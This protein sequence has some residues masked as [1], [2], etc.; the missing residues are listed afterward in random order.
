MS[1]KWSTRLLAACTP[2]LFCSC[3]LLPQHSDNPP[4]PA[5]ANMAYT[6]EHH[7]SALAHYAETL[8]Q[9][10]PESQ[11]QEI[12]QAEREYA[13][14]R[15]AIIRLRLAL[16]LALADDEFRDLDRASA[17]LADTA[18]DADYPVH[19][20]LGRLLSSLVGSLKIE[21]EKGDHCTLADHAAP[22]HSGLPDSAQHDEVSRLA[23]ELEMER[24]HCRELQMKL[25]EL[26][27]IERQF[28]EREQPGTPPLER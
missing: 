18:A 22:V 5:V 13:G 26:K 24:E 4:R 2:V 27:A 14:D 16:A 11:R 23:A 21:D 20:G 17:L 10:T 15:R 9:L 7:T 19:L 12:E 28:S 1:P 25:E 8:A 6:V 3:A